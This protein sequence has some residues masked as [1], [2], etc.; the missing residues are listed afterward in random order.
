VEDPH[1]E[2]VKHKAFCQARDIRGR[3]YINEQGVNAQLSGGGND[4]EAYATWVTSDPRFAGTRVSVYDSPSGHAFPRLTLRY[5]SGLVQLE[6]GTQHLPVHDPSQ[7]AKKLKPEEWHAM[8]TSASDS[9]ASPQA[10]VVID[11]RNGYEWDA[12]RFVSAS[13]PPVESFRETVE[14]YSAPGGPLDGVPEDVPIMM[15]CTG[16]IRCDFYSA[17][18][19]A[20]GVKNALYTLDGGVQAYIDACGPKMRPDSAWDGHL[21]VFDARLAMTGDK[22][23]SALVDDPAE[24]TAQARS[25][26]MCHCCGQ[27]QAVAPH[28][29][30]PN[31][32]CNRLFLVCPACLQSHGGFCCS[33]CSAATH[34][35]PVLV[36]PGQRYS[37]YTHYVDGAAT[38]HNNRRG[39]GR[40]LRK[41]RRKE[42]RA[43]EQYEFTVAAVAETMARQAGLSVVDAQAAA[44]AVVNDSVMSGSAPGDASASAQQDGATLARRQRAARLA[45]AVSHA[46]E[47]VL[48]DSRF[49][50]MRARLKEE[51]AARVAQQLAALSQSGSVESSTTD[52]QSMHH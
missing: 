36:Q 2:V 25:G 19:R 49:A 28:R 27:P 50:K 31:V 26:L 22:R 38:G 11:V 47:G 15:Y 40:R 4:A 13:R 17:A 21:F 8:L 16:G 14:A 34:I 6:G 5:K 1:G 46:P 43:Q 44:I 45:A 41:Q 32:D 52:Q 51:A 23:A 20:K 29:N 35:R 3:I 7:R 30:C 37:R 42:R 12:G 39:E 9:H 24:N 33:T 10:P 48:G 18:L